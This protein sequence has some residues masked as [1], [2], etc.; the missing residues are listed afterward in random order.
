MALILCQLSCITFKHSHAGQLNKRWTANI[1]HLGS[2]RSADQPISQV[3][4]ET[5]PLL[6]ITEP[7]IEW[8]LQWVHN[9]LG[10]TKGGQLKEKKFKDHKLNKNCL[11]ELNC[12]LL[13]NYI[14]SRGSRLNVYGSVKQPCPNKSPNKLTRNI[15]KSVSETKSQLIKWLRMT[16][17]WNSN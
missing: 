13:V 10:S 14:S 16:R 7:D 1:S 6:C 8:V 15:Q 12:C 4:C 11:L 5:K 3:C 17:L 9:M 2:C